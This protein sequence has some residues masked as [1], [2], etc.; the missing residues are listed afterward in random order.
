MP[1]GAEIAAMRRAIA[2]P[3]AGFGSTSPNPP[4]GCVV[5]GAGGIAELRR[6]GVDV[7]TGVLAAEASIVLGGWLAALGTRRPAITWPYDLCDRGIEALPPDTTEMHA[8]RLNA[9]AVLSP[10]GVVREAVPDRHGIGILAVKDQSPDSG[11]A[12]V[13]ASLYDCGVRYLLL[14]GGPDVAAPSSLHGW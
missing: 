13:A 10:G 7:E 3:A 5:L 12:G 11:A 4:V 8:L 14:E 6:A 2:L 1:T 9:D